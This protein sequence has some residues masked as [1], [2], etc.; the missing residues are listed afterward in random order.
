MIRLE[1][2][3]RLSAISISLVP[4]QGKSRSIAAV[5]RRSETRKIAYATPT[6]LVFVIESAASSSHLEESTRA[7]FLD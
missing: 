6:T 5:F 2:Q 1:A 3:G 7:L 4:H